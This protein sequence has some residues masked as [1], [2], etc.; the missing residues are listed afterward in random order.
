MILQYNTETSSAVSNRVTVT[1][2]TYIQE[3]PQTRRDMVYAIPLC[4]A[5]TPPHARNLAG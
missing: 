4:P 3:D 5:I 1:V 2:L